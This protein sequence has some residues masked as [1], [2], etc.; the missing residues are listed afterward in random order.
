MKVKLTRTEYDYLVNILL[1]EHTEIISKVRFA[2]L[3][4]DVIYVYMIEFT[5][6][7]I[8]ELT[9]GRLDGSVFDENYEPT[10]EGWILE[11]FIDKFYV[12]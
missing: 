4:K 10:P 3:D 5:A 7:D 11:H 9:E 8:R 1:K 2:N 12:G 6:D